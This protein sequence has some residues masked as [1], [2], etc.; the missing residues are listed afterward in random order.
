V[1]GPNAKAHALIAYYDDSPAGFALYYY[2]F[3]T[4]QGLPG[5]YLE[6]LYVNTEMRGK[7]IGQA[8]LHRLAQIAKCEGCW[9]IEWAVLH[10]NE[11]AI[12]FYKKLGAKPMNE[13]SV[14]R[15]SGDALDR[16]AGS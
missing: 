9:R 7:G 11:S 14:Y 4:F 1:F 16:L 3:S 2:T 15:L 8:L 10:W 5:L 13:W 6:D 12:G